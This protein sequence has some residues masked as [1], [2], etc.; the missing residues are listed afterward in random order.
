[1]TKKPEVSNIEKDDIIFTNSNHM[2]RQI[3]QAKFLMRSSV[4]GRCI[5]LLGIHEWS[6]SLTTETTMDLL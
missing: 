1:L 4:S 3:Q 5:L 6:R 2:F